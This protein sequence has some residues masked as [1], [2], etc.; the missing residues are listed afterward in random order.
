M[1]SSLIRQMLS[2]KIDPER[3]LVLIKRGLHHWNFRVVGPEPL[4]V[5]MEELTDQDAKNH[6]LSM[7][8]EHFRAVNPK[9]RIPRFQQWRTALSADGML[10]HW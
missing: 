10:P 3:W 5:E 1:S 6:A 9:V 2:A 7:A 4:D 8:K